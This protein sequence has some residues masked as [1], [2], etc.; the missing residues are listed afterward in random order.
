MKAMILAAGRGER[1]RPL[2]DH[3]PKPLLVVR[4]KP[5][6]QHHVEAL[7]TAGFTRLVVNLSWHG[8]RIREFLG[9][10]AAYGASIEYSE[11]PEALETA[12]GIRQALDLLGERFVVVN[13]DILTSYDFSRL[14]STRD[15]AYL[16]LVENPAHNSGGDFGLAGSRVQNDGDPRY[17]F[18]GIGAYTRAFFAELEPGKKALAPLLRAAAER[19]E[20][21]GELFTG[22]WS[23]VGT[24][25]RLA[26]LNAAGR[27]H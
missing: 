24:P 10:G 4:G 26:A 8:E 23:D 18:S 7:V 13:A 17:T 3:T 19:G 20:L 22:D 14:R 11:E 12:G 15:P 21:G 27:D 5:L 6:I 1:M 16:V 2:T 25:E 9:D